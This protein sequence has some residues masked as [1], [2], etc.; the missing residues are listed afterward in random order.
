MVNKLNCSDFES[1][2][3][4]N[5]STDVVNGKII[6]KAVSGFSQFMNFFFLFN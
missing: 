5:T 2:C 6:Y 1:N 3:Q 4:F